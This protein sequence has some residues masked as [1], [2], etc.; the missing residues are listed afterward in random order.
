MSEWDEYADQWDGDERVIHYSQQA[1]QSLTQAIN[2]NGL[3]ILD[4]GCGTSR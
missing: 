1:Y 2:C 3:T 4:F